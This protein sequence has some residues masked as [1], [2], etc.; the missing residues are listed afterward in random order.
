[1]GQAGS[2]G[3]WIGER[4]GAVAA[5]WGHAASRLRANGQRG[6]GWQARPVKERKRISEIRLIF[7]SNTDSKIK[8]K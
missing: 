2:A 7:F 8:S 3:T 5:E 4:K 1:M 6:S